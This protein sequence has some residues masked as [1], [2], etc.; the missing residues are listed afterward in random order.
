ME[1]QLDQRERNKVLNVYEARYAGTIEEDGEGEQEARRRLEEDLGE[2][3]S[4]KDYPVPS[5]C[6]TYVNNLPVTWR[7]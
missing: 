5:R 7:G 6:S 1:N 3:G 2:L 4:Y